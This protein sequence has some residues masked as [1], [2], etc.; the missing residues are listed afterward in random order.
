MVSAPAERKPGGF[1]HPQLALAALLTAWPCVCSE[2]FSFFS[3]FSQLYAQ[4]A[5]SYE[6]HLDLLFHVLNVLTVLYRS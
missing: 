6:L 1:F 4:G 5:L 3:G 2:C